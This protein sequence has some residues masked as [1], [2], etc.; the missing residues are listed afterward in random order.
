MNKIILVLT[1]LLLMPLSAIAQYSPGGGVDNNSPNSWTQP[2]TFTAPLIMGT[3]QTIYNTEYDNGNSSTAITIDFNNGNQQKLTLTGNCT[4]TFNAPTNGVT[5]I[6]LRIVQGGGGPY[7]IT[8]PT[9]TWAGGVKPPTASAS[10]VDVAA[11]QYTTVDSTYQGIAS[12][13]FQ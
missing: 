13:N 7:T 10:A 1:C 9:M 8:W 3:Q 2:Q 6:R 12:L 4:I 11:V 5:A